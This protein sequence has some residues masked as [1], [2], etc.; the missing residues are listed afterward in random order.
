MLEEIKKVLSQKNEKNDYEDL[1]LESKEC[2][3]EIIAIINRIKDGEN[4]NELFDRIKAECEND[5]LTGALIKIINSNVAPFEETAFLRELDSEKFNSLIKYMLENTIIQVE[6]KKHVHE[7]VGLEEKKVDTLY[8]LMYTVLNWII[9]KRYSQ[10]HFFRDFNDMFRFDEDKNIFIWD[11]F[12]ERRQELIFAVL[13]DSVSVCFEIKD[14]I[15][16]WSDLFSS[17]FEENKEL[18][19]TKETE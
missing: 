13:L 11:L 15:D 16:N 7:A 14:Q 12:V 2:K 19:E 3:A 1:V 5:E 6:L 9:T 10:K 17:I 18:S 8:R 4:K